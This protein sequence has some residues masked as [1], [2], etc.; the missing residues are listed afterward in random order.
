PRVPSEASVVGCLGATMANLWVSNIG[1]PSTLQDAA[2]SNDSAFGAVVRIERLLARVIILEFLAIAATCFLT[3]VIYF[4]AALTQW[5]PAVEYVT[6]A[7][8]IAALVVLPSLAFKQYNTIQSQ[9]RD[10]FMWSGLGAVFLAFA[11]FLSILFLCKIAN[12]YSRGT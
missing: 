3:S 1:R 4:K 12:W 6:A 11:A 5:P 2:V 10:R 8:L 7:F 9:A